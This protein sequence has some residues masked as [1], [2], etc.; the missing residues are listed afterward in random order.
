MDIPRIHKFLASGTVFDA[1]GSKETYYISS[2]HDDKYIYFLLDNTGLVVRYDFFQETQNVIHSVISEPNIEINS[3]ILKDNK[4]YGFPG[5]KV[6][7]F[8]NNTVLYIQNNQL[9]TNTFNFDNKVVLLQSRSPLIDFIIKDNYDYLI[10]HDK[11]KISCFNKNRILQYKLDINTI[12]ELSGTGCMLLA[13]DIVS[14]YTNAG[15]KTY[16]IIFGINNTNSFFGKIDE[17]NQT[18]VNVTLVDKIDNTLPKKFCLTNYTYLR[19][20]YLS[21]EIA[22]RLR[23]KN[24]LNNQNIIEV[25]LPVST[26]M[27][28]TGKHHFI[29]QVSTREGV[30][31]LFV[32]DKLIAN[33][34]LPSGQFTLQDII[35]DNILAGCTGFYNGDTLAKYLNQNKYYFING[36]KISKFRIYNKFLDSNEIQFL[37]LNNEKIED[38]IASIPADQRNNIETLSRLFKVQQP[39]RKSN[40]INININNSKILDKDIQN[41]LINIINEKIE[42]ILP[43][44]TKI[45]NISFNEY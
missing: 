32:D 21:P 31:N 20:K 17:I 37:L 10:L 25:S 40:N 2:C 19:E 24:E 13:I 26:A 43:V 1:Q 30:V 8:D 14:E 4:L 35:T 33:A 23:F 18:I 39:G 12:S 29:F 41:E 5:T 6:A 36:A 28:S 9:I 7:N 34:L 42:A 15:Y 27:F 16:P 38:L 22:F 44:N 3:I 11:T 45:N